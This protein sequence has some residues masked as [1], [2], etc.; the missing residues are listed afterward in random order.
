MTSIPLPQFSL[1][2]SSQNSR[3]L[4]TLGV[5]GERDHIRHGASTGNLD[6]LCEKITSILA[7]D[8]QEIAETID[9]S[10]PT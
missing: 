7:E 5:L 4:E 3:S 9:V 2:C 6:F 10:S 8:K 1:A